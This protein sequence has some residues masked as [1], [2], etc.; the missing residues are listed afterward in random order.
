MAEMSRMT[1]SAGM[2]TRSGTTPSNKPPSNAPAI[3]PATHPAQRRGLTPTP[4]QRGTRGAVDILHRAAVHDACQNLPDRGV[5]VL[6]HLRPARPGV[7]ESHANGE[8]RL[9]LSG[10]NAV[11][12]GDRCRS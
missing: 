11:L 5:E 7:A 8:P 1:V 6:K 4:C 2:R 9:R 10:S 3:D 12:V